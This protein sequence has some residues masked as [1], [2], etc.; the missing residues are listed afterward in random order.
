MK[1]ILIKVI[2]NIRVVTKEDKSNAFLKK[3]WPGCSCQDNIRFKSVI[4]MM[5]AG[6]IK[7]CWWV[8]S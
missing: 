3:D 1:T 8:A 6:M 4:K 2:V 7:N 5:L